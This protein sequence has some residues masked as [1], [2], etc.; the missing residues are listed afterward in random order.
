MTCGTCIFLTSN[1]HLKTTHVHGRLCWFC[2]SL[3]VHVHIELY[4]RYFYTGYCC[5]VLT[6]ET[7]MVTMRFYIY[8]KWWDAKLQCT[9]SCSITPNLMQCERYIYTPTIHVQRG[10][11]ASCYRIPSVLIFSRTMQLVDDEERVFLGQFQMTS[12]TTN[13]RAPCATCT[14]PSITTQ[15]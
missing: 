12:K 4:N 15:I 11:W 7:C 6:I 2:G 13:R 9:E 5:I 1:L 3:Y 8:L 14:W 10:P